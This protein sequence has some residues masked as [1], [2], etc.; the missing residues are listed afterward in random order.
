MYIY[1]YTYTYIYIYIC[2]YVLLICLL[3]GYTEKCGPKKYKEISNP[4]KSVSM[5][6]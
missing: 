3:L 5:C 2:L 6:F 4:S 1:I